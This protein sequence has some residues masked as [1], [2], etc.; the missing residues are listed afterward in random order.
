MTILLYALL[1]FNGFDGHRAS[2]A[3][4]VADH[5]K[6][7]PDCEA[8]QI[9]SILPLV[10]IVEEFHVN[11]LV[12]GWFHGGKIFINMNRKCKWTDSKIAL[13]LIHEL[14][15]ACGLCLNDSIRSYAKPICTVF[16]RPIYH[17]EDLTRAIKKHFR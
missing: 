15:H 11:P 17:S 10:E 7:H 6:G 3:D 12:S 14:I 13:F 4:L 16:D 5:L 2:V 8:R 9:L 1:I